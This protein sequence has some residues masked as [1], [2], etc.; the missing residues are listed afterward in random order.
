MYI[1]MY[2]NMYIKQ[3]HTAML[4][5]LQANCISKVQILCVNDM[6]TEASFLFRP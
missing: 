3:A 2:I 6:S 4:N 1:N 5:I